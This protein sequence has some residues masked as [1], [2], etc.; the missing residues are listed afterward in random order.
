MLSNDKIHPRLAFEHC[1]MFPDPARAFKESNEYYAAR[2]AEDEKELQ[3][4]MERQRL[5]SQNSNSKF[6]LA[7]LKDK[8]DGQSN[9]GGVDE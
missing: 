4:E 3:D 6:Q 8:L 5:E 9:D 7:S 1:G 2:K